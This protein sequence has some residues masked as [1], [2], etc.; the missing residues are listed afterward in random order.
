M[1]TPLLDDL[2][3]RLVVE[4]GVSPAAVLAAGARA[5]GGWL[6]ATGAAGE[7]S[8]GHPEPVTAETPFDLASVTKP[9]VACTA[10]RLIRNRALGFVTPLGSVVPEL[11]DTASGARTIAELLSHRAGLEAH[12]PL[13]GPLL[14]GDR[15]DVGRALRAAADARRPDCAGEPPKEGFEPVYSD[16]GYLL[17]GEAIARAGGAPLADVVHREV[18]EPLDLEVRSAS[19]FLALQPDF[20]RLVAPTEVVPFRGGE[21]IGKVHDENAWALGGFGICGHAGLFGTARSVVEF[22]AAVL[23]ALSGHR[24]DWLLSDDVEP[25]VRVRAGG[26]LRA[27]FDGRAQTGSAAGSRFG[28]RAFGHLGFTGTSLWCDPEQA[29]V[30]VILTNRVSPS[31][32]NVAIR[33]VRPALGDALYDAGLALRGGAGPSL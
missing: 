2:A 17:A 4:S 5:A 25:L 12:L 24:R 11:A 22:G 21:I 15:V 10:A 20:E 27:G 31:R 1:R 13:Y 8:A 32:D 3:R 26:T 19:Q 23:D 30:A 6:V 9:F 28:P 16:L 7:R 29:L 33:A 18:I 14:R